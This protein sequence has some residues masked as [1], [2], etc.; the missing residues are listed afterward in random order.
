MAPHT[1]TAMTT[2]RDRLEAKV[3]RSAGPDA[4]HPFRG[5]I[6]RAG[7]G[8]L[9]RGGREEPVDY[10]HRIAYELAVG[11]IP[12]GLVLDHRCRRRECCNPRHL[13]PVTNA[14][15][16][17]RGEAPTIVLNRAGKCQRGHDAS[18]ASRRSSGPRAGQVAYCRACRREDRAAAR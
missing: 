4:C 14:A 18:E 16:I 17:G 9:R 8:R 10:A 2:L 11:P 12:E 13:E 3:D 5:F 15:N 1:L 6:D 7:Y